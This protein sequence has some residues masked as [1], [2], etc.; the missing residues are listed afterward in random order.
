MKESQPEQARHLSLTERAKIIAET[1]VSLVTAPL[2]LT[3]TVRFPLGSKIQY[4][5]PYAEVPDGAEGSATLHEDRGEIVVPTG[6]TMVAI[7]NGV[8]MIVRDW[9][10]NPSPLLR[11]NQATI[12]IGGYLRTNIDPKSRV[13]MKRRVLVRNI[14][15]QERE[16]QVLQAP[17]IVIAHTSSD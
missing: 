6:S 13:T 15:N 10:F 1:A 9:K 12:N 4:F 8:A 16:I 5:N 2:F 11:S 14:T 7:I 3:T 17:P